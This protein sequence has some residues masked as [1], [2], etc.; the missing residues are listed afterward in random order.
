MAREILL[1]DEAVALGGLHAGISGAYSYPG[2]PATEILEY[3]QRLSKKWPSVH[4]TWSANE[5]VAY[6]EALGMSAVGKRSMVSMKHVG[7]NVAADPFVNS[8]I[9]GAGGG[10]MLCVADDPGMHSSQNEQDSRYYAEFAMIPCLEP[11]NQQ[12]AYDATRFAFDLSEK[13]GIPVMMRLV[14]RLAH[15]R[16]DV[17]VGEPRGENNLAPQLDWKKWTLLPAN[18]RINFSKL[19]DKQQALAR[20]AHL[21]PFNRLVEGAGERAY[22]VSGVAYNYFREAVGNNTPPYLKISH[23]PIPVELI[24]QLVQ[25]RH[26]IV[27]IEDG[28]PFIESRLRGILGCGELK[29]L[30]KL[31]GTL[32]RTGELTPDIVAAAVRGEAPEQ[33]KSPDLPG[34]P[35]QLCQG[36]SH[37]DTYAALKEALKNYPQAQVFSDIGCYTLGALEPYNAINS[38]VDMGASISMAAGATHAGLRPAVAMIGDSTFGHSGMT[39]LLDAAYQDVPMIVIIGDNAT[40]GMT[41][42]Q[43]SMTTGERLISVLKG[44][45]VPEGH[46]RVI[47]PMPKNREKFMRVL[48][49]EIE[50]DGLSVIVASRICIQ[51]ARRLKKKKSS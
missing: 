3:I 45:G 8:A 16:A 1:G 33:P 4:C 9:T 41:G 30:G 29:V 27:V 28:F 32:P 47:E 13:H 42:G 36:C 7:L 46:I 24:H 48:R 37:A 19:V 15:S 35:P 25:G 5:K 34:R 10:M 26:E 40:T 23:Y 39:S 44:L 14:T 51:E 38:C 11:S 18:A 20:E 31:S 43:L 50:H 49:E 2:T 21:S 12:E 17:E 6:E 22:I